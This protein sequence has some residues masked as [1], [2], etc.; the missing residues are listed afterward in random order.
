MVLRDHNS[1]I[2]EIVSPGTNI[3]N[4]TFSNNLMSIYLEE[5][6]DYKTKKPILGLSLSVIDVSTGKTFTYETHSLA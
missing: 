2:T 3:N 5:L 4:N 1:N 6:K